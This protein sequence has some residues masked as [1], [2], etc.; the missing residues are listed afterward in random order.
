M[1]RICE[2]GYDGRSSLHTAPDGGHALATE[3][4]R[5]RKRRNAL[6]GPSKSL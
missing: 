6:S 3:G 1:L 4:G 2:G 5:K